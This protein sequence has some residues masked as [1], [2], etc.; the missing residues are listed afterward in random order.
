[1]GNVVS[2]TPPPSPIPSQGGGLFSGWSFLPKIE[3]NV[4]FFGESSVSATPSPTASP[5]A[6]L[7]QE[8]S[9]SPTATSSPLSTSFPPQDSPVPSM[10]NWNVE[11]VSFVEEPQ[12]GGNLSTTRWQVTAGDTTYTYTKCEGNGGW[13]VEATD[14]DP[15]D[16][17]HLSF[18]ETHVEG[19]TQ[20]STLTNKNVVAETSPSPTAAPTASPEASAVVTKTP[21]ATGKSVVAETSPSP[22]AIPPKVS[23]DVPGLL[24]SARSWVT[25]PLGNIVRVPL[26]FVTD[27][28]KVLAGASFVGSVATAGASSYGVYRFGKEA[29]GAFSSS[30]KEYIWQEP[31]ARRPLA[32]CALSAAICVRE[33]LCVGGRIMTGTYV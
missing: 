31:K 8:V 9:S 32:L 17:T 10:E 18:K 12:D 28:A 2:P 23:S 16:S 26:G 4:N 5:T 29:L 25:T 7:V 20:T 21:A 27:S 14:I 24:S 15:Q 13:C 30:Q 1:M 11:K 3:V 22:T 19:T 6:S 33:V